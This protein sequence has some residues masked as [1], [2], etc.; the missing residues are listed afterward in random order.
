MDNIDDEDEDTRDQVELSEPAGAAKGDD[1]DDDEVDDLDDGE[2]AEDGD[3]VEA[4]AE[5]SA[6]P[7][8]VSRKV[9]RRRRRT[10]PR[11]KT[12]ARRPPIHMMRPARDSA[13]HSTTR[14]VVLNDLSAVL[15]VSSIMPRD[16][17]P[18]RFVMPVTSSRCS[19]VFMNFISL[20]VSAGPTVSLISPRRFRIGINRAARTLRP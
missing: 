13:S 8:E 1:L 20:I 2:D 15:P 10:R 5:A 11:S 14:K 17:T 19:P 4:S 18:K 7:P 9:R 6:E 16:L 12:I 3:V